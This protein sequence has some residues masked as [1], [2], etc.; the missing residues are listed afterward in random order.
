[1]DRKYTIGTTWTPIGGGDAV[2]IQNDGPSDVYI[3][4]ESEVHEG[5]PWENNKSPLK[6][7]ENLQ[8]DQIKSR[9]LGFKGK[10]AVWWAICQTGSAIVRTFGQ[11]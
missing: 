11:S 2:S 10:A 4:K 1:M 9:F 5:Y 6:K 3:V 8:R 7:G